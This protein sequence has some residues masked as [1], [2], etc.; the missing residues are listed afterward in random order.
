MEEDGIT[1][2]H[3]GPAPWVSNTVMAPKDDGKVRVTIDM[4]KPN[5]AIRDNNIP[6]PRVEEKRAK[7]AGSSLF[8]KLDFK[9]AFHQL[10][11]SPQSRYITVFN[12]GEKLKHYT[13]LTMG[14]KPASGELNKALR[15]LL[16]DIRAAHVI[17]RRKT[18][19]RTKSEANKIQSISNYI[20]TIVDLIILKPIQN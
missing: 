5:V 12:D 7:L 3:H 17:R 10:E 16:N 14:T 11:L 8:T 18:R 4:R 9:C 13:R 6:I 15:P 20:L 1:E 19:W 2:D